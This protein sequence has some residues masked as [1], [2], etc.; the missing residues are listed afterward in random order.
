MLTQVAASDGR[1]KLVRDVANG[2][3]RL[4]DR[5]TDPGETTDRRAE[6]IGDRDR[7]AAPLD[8]WI[9]AE[10]VTSPAQTVEDAKQFEQR[11]RNLGY[12]E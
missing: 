4:Y 5:A 6:L 12:V 9:A 1:F 7:L 11:L 10:H 3:E 8:A 2:A